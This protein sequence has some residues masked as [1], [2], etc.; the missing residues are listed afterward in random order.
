MSQPQTKLAAPFW[1]SAA[2]KAKGKKSA[3]GT[4]KQA[5]INSG[6]ELRICDDPPPRTTLGPRFS[7]YIESFE[8]LPVGKGLEC[9][10]GKAGPVANAMRAWIKRSGKEGLSVISVSD[11]GDGKGRVWL[12]KTEKEAAK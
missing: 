5:Q 1:P 2:P 3:T 6:E 9:S 11:Y 4:V 7:K 10:K 8:K 12:V